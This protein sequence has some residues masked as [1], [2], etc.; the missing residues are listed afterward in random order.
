MDETGHLQLDIEEQVVQLG[1]AIG[2]LEKT[3][4]NDILKNTKYVVAVHA[5]GRESFGLEICSLP[6]NN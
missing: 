5:R 2:L 1:E 6:S 3:K 4:E